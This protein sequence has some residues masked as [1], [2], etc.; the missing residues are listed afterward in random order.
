MQQRI[1]EQLEA[2]RTDLLRRKTSTVADLV[3]DVPDRKGDT[4]DITVDEQLESAQLLIETRLA[5]ELAEIDAALQ[6]ISDGS[7]GECEECGD[8]I[9]TRRLEIQPMA[10]MCVECLETQETEEQRRYKRPGLLDEF[11]D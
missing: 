10:R 3:D 9:P 1:R 6:R 11:G 5:H 8:T 2:R 7:Y 4:I